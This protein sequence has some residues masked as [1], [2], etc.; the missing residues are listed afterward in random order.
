MTD[1]VPPLTDMRCFRRYQACR[2]SRHR[3]LPGGEDL[4]E[5]LLAAI[6]EE[7][8]KFAAGVLAGSTGLAIRRALSSSTEWCRRRMAGT[9]LTG[10]SS[11][12]GGTRCRSIRLWR[13]GFAAPRCD[14][15]VRPVALAN[16]AFALYPMLTQAAVEALS[17]AAPPRRKTSTLRISSP[18]NG[19]GTMQLTEPQAGSDLAVRSKAVKEGD[20]YR[21][22]GQKIFITYGDHELTE[23]LIHM[24][25]ARTPDAPA[26]VKGISLFIV[27][28][29][30]VSD[31]GS[32]GARKMF[33]AFRSKKNGHSRKPDGSDGVWRK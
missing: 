33:A 24:V 23:N 19:P 14:A 3:Q 2:L 9:T 6:F 5:D 20:H 10:S 11:K 30:M 8:G 17:Q 32:P 13:A 31:D 1:Y 12:A 27:P 15:V 21:I 22:S 29:F 18:A 26:G 25:L 4:N 7:G 28:K 16:M